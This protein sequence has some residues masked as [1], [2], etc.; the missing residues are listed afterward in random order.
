MRARGCA[1]AISA[2]SRSPPSARKLPRRRA[3]DPRQPLLRIGEPAPVRAQARRDRA[4]GAASSSRVRGRAHVLALLRAVDLAL[5]QLVDERRDLGVA[6]G[7]PAARAA[8]A[9]APRCA[10]PPPCAAPAARRAPRRGCPCSSFISASSISRGTARLGDLGVGPREQR[11]GA[12]SKSRV[13]IA[14]RAPTSAASPDDCGIASASSANLRAPCR[15][16]PRAARRRRRPASPARAPA[17][18]GAAQRAPRR[19]G[20]SARRTIRSSDV[21]ARRSRRPASTQQQVE[22][23]LDAVGRRDE[24]RIAGR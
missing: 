5:D 1:R 12:P 20:R 21:A 15:S 6:A 3:R 10:S 7:A 19:A 14:A 4:G 18:A 24:Q 22:R 2:A 13:S 16:G 23:E 9:A 17:A 11:L 8:R